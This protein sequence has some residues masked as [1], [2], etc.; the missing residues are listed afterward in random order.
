MN[1]RDSE[2][3]QRNYETTE[4]KE[5]KVFADKIYCKLCEDYKIKVCSWEESAAWN[6][7]V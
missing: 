7:Y 1:T 5:R 4:N 3:G 6:E 2:D